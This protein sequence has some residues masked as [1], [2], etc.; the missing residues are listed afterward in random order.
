M[1]YHRILCRVPW[2]VESVIVAY[3]YVFYKSVYP[4]WAPDLSPPHFFPHW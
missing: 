2:P 1:G 4:F 3:V